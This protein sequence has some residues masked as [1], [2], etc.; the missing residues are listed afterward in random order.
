MKAQAK[1]LLIALLVI[2][3]IVLA[4]VLRFRWL[5]R[6]REFSS[7]L[8]L[9]IPEITSCSAYLDYETL[10]SYSVQ[11]SLEQA[12][13]LLD[14]LSQPDYRRVGPAEGL[15]DREFPLLRIFLHTSGSN[16]CELMLNG[17]EMLVS[18]HEGCSISYRP[19]D[20]RAH[21]AALTAFLEDCLTQNEA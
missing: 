18:P 5:D 20:S 3:A 10:E 16:R 15:S 9:S 13:E 19:E 8:P 17:E 6:P 1:Q 21:H 4:A 7:L 12:Q 2:A 14:M 11:L